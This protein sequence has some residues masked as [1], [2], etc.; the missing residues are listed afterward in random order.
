MG[1]ADRD[2]MRRTPGR[3]STSVTVV[4]LAV[5]A[6]VWLLLGF[7]GAQRG[8][9]SGTRLVASLGL[10]WDGLT[11]GKVWTLL[12]HAVTHVDTQHILYN[13]IGVWVFGRMVEGSMS[14]SAYL[15][16][17]LFAAV[18]SGLV[19]VGWS[20]TDGTQHVPAIGV[21]GVL[22]ALIAIAALR[23][24][25]AR[26]VLFPIPI[27]VPLWLLGIGYVFLDLRGLWSGAGHVAFA[28]H[29]G[30]FLAGLIVWWLGRRGGGRPRVEYESPSD[31]GRL[32]D[33]TRLD[34]LL[35]RINREG[36]QSLSPEDRAFLERMSKRR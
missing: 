31:P 11:A 21:S 7:T 22:M 33:A 9:A 25:R 4:L 16:T 29:L 8:G 18:F 26:M 1:L 19:Y 12:T 14:R 23:F 15:R 17:L 30:G 13:A 3:R 6:A 2:Y 36:I 34:N 20:L 10:S 28:G 35:A 24:P 32:D 5:C 27:P